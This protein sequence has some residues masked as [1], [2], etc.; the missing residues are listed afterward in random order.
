MDAMVADLKR[1]VFDIERDMSKRKASTGTKTCR[2]KELLGKGEFA[3]TFA[4]ADQ[5]RALKIIAMPASAEHSTWREA[6]INEIATQ[7]KASQLKVAPNIYTHREEESRFLIEMDRCSPP[8][9]DATSASEI[10]I[11][12]EEMVNKGI[13]QNDLHQG[14]FM[15]LN[16]KATIIDFGLAKYLEIKLTQQ[17]SNLVQAMHIAQLLEPYANDNTLWKKHAEGHKFKSTLRA[18]FDTLM[19]DYESFLSDH[20]QN[21]TQQYIVSEINNTFPKSHVYVK[22]QCFGALHAFLNNLY[23]D[24]EDSANAD[25][26][27]AIRQLVHSDPVCIPELWLYLQGNGAIKAICS[28]ILPSAPVRKIEIES[29]NTKGNRRSARIAAREQAVFIERHM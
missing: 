5:T 11:C 21:N 13:F 6:V 29:A 8:V 17:E 25:I 23:Q 12:V 15:T 26:F 16:D 22:L 14:N 18:R 24:D 4:C 27:W 20:D 7:K 28:K 9:F 1:Q 10:A 19:Q 2:R 3:R